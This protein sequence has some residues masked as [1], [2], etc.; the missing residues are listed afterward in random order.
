MKSKREYN[1]FNK[2][3]NKV[4]SLTFIARN[5]KT[6]MGEGDVRA[7]IAKSQSFICIYEL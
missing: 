6:H 4:F 7:K 2:F 1:S 5:V 3:E